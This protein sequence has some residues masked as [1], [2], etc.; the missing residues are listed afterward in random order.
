VKLRPAHSAKLLPP[1]KLLPVG[2]K[3]IRHMPPKQQPPTQTDLD[4]DMPLDQAVKEVLS[5][6]PP[7]VRVYLTSGKYSAVAQQ[8][9][10]N[11]SLHA[12]QAMLLER[13]LI[14]LITGSETPVEFGMSLIEE[15][16]IPEDTVR[17]IMTDL[18]KMVFMP[19][20]EQMK[21]SMPSAPSQSTAPKPAPPP[22]AYKPAVPPV[23]QAIPRPASPAPSAQ[24]VQRPVPAPPANLPGQGGFDHML[25]DREEPH[26]NVGAAP[27]PASRPMPQMPPPPISQPQQF[28]AP[29]PPARPAPPPAPPPIS[30]PAAAPPT[31]TP[32]TTPPATKPY[33]TDPYREPFEL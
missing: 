30:R 21:N 16:Q 9:M 7:A 12:D 26:I 10:Q 27:M 18:N 8:L 17:S 28:Q 24:P 4:T 15:G 32:P 31:P 5:T 13:E 29:M 23:P 20:Q 19:L 14:L 25:E 1:L 11:Y 33:A 6:L 3:H 22:P 2:K